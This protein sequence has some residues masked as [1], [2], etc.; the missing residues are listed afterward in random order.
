MSPTR[1]R[2]R[3]TE[4]RDHLFKSKT[5]QGLQLT[6]RMGLGARG[7]LTRGRVRYTSSALE[8]LRKIA[9]ISSRAN[10]PDAIAKQRRRPR[11]TRAR[12]AMKAGSKALVTG[13]RSA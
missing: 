3:E 4:L 11:S 8:M 10:H 2:D 13:S 1:Q 6:S 9:I 5:L 7:M 12:Q